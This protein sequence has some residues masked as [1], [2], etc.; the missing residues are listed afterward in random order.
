MTYAAKLHLIDEGYFKEA[1]ALDGEISQAIRSD[2]RDTVGNTL[3][4]SSELIPSE[5]KAP[6]LKRLL[7]LRLSMKNPNADKVFLTSH[8]RSMRRQLVK[9]FLSSCVAARRCE[10]CSAFSPKIRQDS[11][12]KIFQA[13]LA[14]RNHKINLAERVRMRA[15]TE[16]LHLMK[17]KE[18]QSGDAGGWESDESD[19]EGDA[20]DLVDYGGE[21]E[22]NA[23]IEAAGKVRRA[24]DKFLHALEIEAQ[25]KLTWRQHPLLCAK[26]F[27][28]P[29]LEASNDAEGNEGHHDPYEKGYKIF[30]MRAICVPPSRFR[31]PMHVGTIVAEHAQNH[32]LSKM[33]D[34]NKKILDQFAVIRG[35]GEVEKESAYGN[36][37]MDRALLAD[38][39]KKDKAHEL[40]YQTWIDLQTTANCYIDSSKDP[41]SNVDSANIGIKQILEKKEGLFRK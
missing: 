40:L 35:D 9:D 18:E 16:T 4:L 5:S 32:Y 39:A 17:K 14:D 36:D 6:A 19:A 27:G 41:E 24:G 28:A 25:V 3:G 23:Q 2:S 33:L 7:E 11:C 29:D 37:E 20:E 38:K 34:L 12:N 10:S 13:P 1:L 31:P 30:F 21:G 26:V 15:A 22:D 8:E